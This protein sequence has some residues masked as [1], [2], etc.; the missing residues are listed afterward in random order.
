MDEA[1]DLRLGVLGELSGSLNGCPIGLGGR[2]QRAVLAALVIARGEA[3]PAD[4]LADCVWGEHAPGN[5][6]GA[7][8]SYVSHLRRCLEPQAAARTR[9]GVI[10]KVGPGYAIRLGL[11]A[12]D[13]WRFERAV[14]SGASL[15][16]V[17]AVAVLDDALG[18]WR[19][20][21][22]AE[23][24]DEDWARAEVV[25]LN[26]LRAVARERLLGARL[27]LG[28]A[29]LLVS[30]LEALVAEDPLRE[31]RWALLVLA[32]Y[33]SQRQADALAALRRARETLA[34]VLGVDPGP[35]LRML[36]RDVLAQSPTLDPPR[37]PA[38]VPSRDTDDAA[39]RAT[40]VDRATSPVRVA[41][42]DLVDRAT[43][44]AEL[45]AAL[46]AARTG[47][48]GVVL[49][50]GP[51]GIG[52]TRLLSEAAR[53]A[54][55]AG[56][57][58]LSARCSR[59]ERT[60]GFGAV[61]QL[62]EPALLDP[63]RRADLLVG[64]AASAA[65]VF[66]TVAEERR[67]DGTFAV[68]HGLYWLTVDLAAESPLLITVDDVQWCDAGSLRFLGYLVRRLEA[69][70]ALV[71]LA[72]RTGEADA[73]EMLL[74]ELALEPSVSV[75]RPRPLSREAT[76]VVVRDRL[77]S[78]AD[79]AFVSACHQVTS[80]NPLLLHQLS[81]A[82]EA[83]GIRPDVV[84]VDT[85]R[86]VGSRAIAGLVA[87]R[88]RRLPPTATAVA[89]AVA[90][91][92]E[93]ADL[94]TVAQLA[95]LTE[96]AAAA[97]MDTLLRCDVLTDRDDLG[98]A[99]P[100]VRDAVYDDLPLGDRQLLHE[101]AAE[102]LQRRGGG[103]EQVA[104]HLLRAPRRGRA[105]RV[106]SLR[107]AGRTALRR[108]APDSAVELLRRALAES[109]EGPEPVDVLVE[110]GLAET[111]V[112]GPAATVHL[113]E[114]FGALP[115]A[116]A[117]ARVAVA[118]ARTHVFASPP[119]VA[120]AF[121][122]Q[123]AA[124]LPDEVDDAR[125]ALVALQRISGSMGGLAPS[126]Y[127]DGPTPTP[128]GDGDGARMLAA[129]S[130]YERLLDGED[131]VGTIDLARFALAD[132][133]LLE[134]DNGLFWVFAATVLLVADGDLTGHGRDLRPGEGLGA[135]WERARQ[136]AYATGSLFAALS[137]NLWRGYFQ[138]RTG[139]LDD[140]LQSFADA[141]DQNDMWGGSP[142]G[143]TYVAAFTAGA[144]LDRGDLRAA[145]HVIDAARRLPPVGEGT[146][147]LHESAVRLLLAEGRP[148][149]ALAELGMATD[150]FG[151]RNPAW[152][153]WR[154]LKARALADIGDHAAAVA[155]AREEVAL[156][157]RW[158]APSALGASLHRLGELV[159]AGGTGH[160][161]EAVQHLQSGHAPLELARARLALGRADDVTTAE[162]L[163]L[164]R[165]ALQVASACG[166]DGVHRETVAALA[167]RGDA[168]ASERA[169]V[170]RTS[171]RDQQIREL[172]AAGLG[173]NE[174]A[175]RLLLTPGT[176]LAVLAPTTAAGP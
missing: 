74:G 73:D 144:H 148:A 172:A 134:V 25:R 85:V 130:S 142:V 60:F 94:V 16:S 91:L 129:T 108:G 76:A 61:R 40:D 39:I 79:D 146:R 95:G 139:V 20:P 150:P 112:D 131:R 162:A 96:D 153:P 116:D 12:V 27:E 105:D 18:L 157:R 62:F 135:F 55:E 48:G 164:L 170:R 17:D 159:G 67:A 8:Q 89:R 125:Q 78:D 38:L 28:D 155:L 44:A 9:D 175:Q 21:A 58:L 128:R 104:A 84:H 43:E 24:A 145:R 10:A 161:R 31:E 81:R 7:L 166:A 69:V 124:G 13:A 6:T 117:R 3:V 49:V 141:A 120:T 22:Y 15:P 54:A 138:W 26:A 109:G 82:L 102:I 107:E 127:R 171:A 136:H 149:D 114:A 132:D 56:V 4:R 23:Y 72:S 169:P 2:R 167:A 174:V 111:F 160:L 29:P 176:V 118:L 47:T 51:A 53:L 45:S 50:E 59:L 68:L 71:V 126:S 151:I 32:L 93:G 140:A 147:L 101:H 86:A 152:A 70:P 30:E 42:A 64:A 121:A 122:G 103:V 87:L 66:D 80:G 98:F 115:D 46:S 165:Q 123:A 35:R 37:P 63:A 168:A 65:G 1:S 137:A 113:A 77:G 33:R 36:E 41:R 88:L 19:G 119:G 158:G 154:G 90:V 156:L 163:P 75:L 100:L 83:D 57:R 92:G 110:L 5:P 173:I 99:H 143:A 97:A 52:K 133:R 34:E 11:D 14:A 106:A